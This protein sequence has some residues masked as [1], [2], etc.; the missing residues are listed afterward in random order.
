MR[1]K[2]IGRQYKGRRRRRGKRGMKG[3]KEVSV[4]GRRGEN[5][6]QK[7]ETMR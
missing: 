5:N 7:G 4:M 6:K 1:G 2:G 3:E